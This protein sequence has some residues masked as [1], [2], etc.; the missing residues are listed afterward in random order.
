MEM[1]NM[2]ITRGVIGDPLPLF[3]ECLSAAEKVADRRLLAKGRA[4][5]RCRTR[6][7]AEP[8]QMQCSGLF[9][10][11]SRR[12]PVP[13]RSASAT[14]HHSADIPAVFH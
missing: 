3:E 10:I 13:G 1:P 14:R 9:T 11:S 12:N 7:V 6:A 4:A 2:A 5:R 8:G